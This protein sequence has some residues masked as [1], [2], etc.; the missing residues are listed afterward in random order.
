MTLR[1]KSIAVKYHWFHEHLSPGQVE[2]VAIAS[3]DQLAD[4]YTKPLPAHQFI[5][6]R[7][8]LLG[9]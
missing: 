3:K 6:L 7:I 8:I 9:W 2:I 5:K 4:I 1:S